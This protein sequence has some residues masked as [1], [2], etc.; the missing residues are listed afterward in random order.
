VAWSRPGNSFSRVM[1]TREVRLR[2]EGDAKCNGSIRYPRASP[3]RPNT[4]GAALAPSPRQAEA[5]IRR[6]PYYLITA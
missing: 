5:G 3:P 4:C 2:G 1:G 6:L